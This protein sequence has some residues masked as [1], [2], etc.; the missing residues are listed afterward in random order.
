MNTL[1]KTKE[2][3]TDETYRQFVINCLGDNDRRKYFY[4]APFGEDSNVPEDTR[5]LTSDSNNKDNRFVFGFLNKVKID[6]LNLGDKAIFS[7]SEDGNEIKSQIVFR[8]T[9][10][11]EINKDLG[12]NASILVKADGTMEFNGDADFI[13]GF[14]DLKSGFDTLKSDFNTFVNSV[15]NS[16]MHPTA[17]TGP[18]SVPTALGSSSSASIDASKKGNLKI[19]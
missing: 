13:A 3:N 9:G 14:N 11:I 5:G 17:G 16:H 8:N 10:N 6:D 12:S 1:G 18:P 4:V 19:E 15:Y 2:T 7:T